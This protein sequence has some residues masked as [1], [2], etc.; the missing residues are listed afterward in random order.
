MIERAGTMPAKY[1]YG[2]RKV[3]CVCSPH[4]VVVEL[5]SL[6]RCILDNVRVLSVMII[7]CSFDFS[8]SVCWRSVGQCNPPR[9]CRHL[10]RHLTSIPRHRP[11]SPYLLP[12]ALA[13]SEVVRCVF[14]HQR[15]S[16]IYDRPDP[17]RLSSLMPIVGILLNRLLLLVDDDL[18]EA[19]DE[20]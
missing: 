2:K 8:A 17:L 13:Q 11:V 14:P 20:V 4:A 19:G 7:F 3:L 9:V 12:H 15:H 6:I 5:V 10:V 16:A 1:K 18:A